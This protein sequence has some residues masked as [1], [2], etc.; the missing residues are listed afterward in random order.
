LKQLGAKLNL[1]SMD[2]VM[3]QKPSGSTQ[4]ATVDSKSSA[5]ATAETATAD[6]QQPELKVPSVTPSSPST[7]SAPSTPST[8]PSPTA[9]FPRVPMIQSAV[10]LNDSV[11]H[12]SLTAP[13]MFASTPLG[14]ESPAFSD[15]PLP[16]RDQIV[17]VD[18]GIC[19]FVSKVQ[20]AQSLGAVGV[21]IVNGEENL[22]MMGF[23]DSAKTITIP[24][25]M[26]PAKQTQRLKSCLTESPFEGVIVTMERNLDFNEDSAPHRIPS[27]RLHVEGDMHDFVVHTA[28][29]WKVEIVEQENKIFHLRIL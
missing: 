11:L 19:S 24:A 2:S 28:G 20:L 12:F 25:F 5:A 29:G 8:S 3:K 10:P 26:I 13:L 16:Y 9:S 15:D 23:D 1:Q 18:R 6:T 7:P 17:L 14:C 21:L 22:F 27:S 4:E